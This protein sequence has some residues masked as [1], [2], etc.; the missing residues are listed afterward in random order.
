MNATLR[1]LGQRLLQALP[2]IL[3]ASFIVFGLMELISSIVPL[4]LP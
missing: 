4:L 1:I 3:L 2:V